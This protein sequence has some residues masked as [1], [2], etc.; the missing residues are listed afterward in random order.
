MSSPSN[1]LPYNTRLFK[2]IIGPDKKEFAVHADIFARLS[3]PLDVLINGPFSE[4][5][6]GQVVWEDVTE[7]EFDQLRQFAYC[8]DYNCVEPEN[9]NDKDVLD[10][11]R[12]KGGLTT[13]QGPFVPYPGPSWNGLQ[14]TLPYSI[15]D[16][17]RNK[18][19]YVRPYLEFA[20]AGSFD[21]RVT[22]VEAFANWFYEIDMAHLYSMKLETDPIGI[23]SCANLKE[24]IFYHA[25]LHILAEKYC[26]DKLSQITTF[27]LSSLLQTHNW[28]LESIKHIADLVPHVYDNTIVGD[29]IREMIVFHVA[30]IIQ[31]A[32]EVDEFAKMLVDVPEFSSSLVQKIVKYRIFRN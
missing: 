11:N 14:G 10:W 4:A 27:K 19:T 29:P 28:T 12:E 30:A 1:D 15:Y 6:D 23:Q 2:F 26:I 3:K 16:M 24:I 31:D 8:G 18:K 17:Y 7:E 13:L 20:E 5:A 25:D 32:F 22:V 9:P 21:G